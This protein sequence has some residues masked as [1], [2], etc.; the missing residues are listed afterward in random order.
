MAH[1]G[2]KDSTGEPLSSNL[3]VFTPTQLASFD[4]R[5]G[6]PAYIACLGLVYDVTDSFL[7]KG[8]RHQVL[9]DAGRDLTNDL[10]SAPHG[11]DLFDRV[12]LV[13]KLIE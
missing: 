10:R 13:G 12:P 9:H 5:A 11:P 4:G 1:G 7:W 2:T 3:R 8:G 6:R